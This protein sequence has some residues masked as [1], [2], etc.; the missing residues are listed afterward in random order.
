MTIMKISDIIDT[1]GNIITATEIGRF[2]G[3]D[4]LYTFCIALEKAQSQLS[5][6]TTESALATLITRIKVAYYYKILQ[7]G[8]ELDPISLKGNILV[9]GRHRLW[10][11]ILHGDT[12]VEYIR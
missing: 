3:T 4:E 11:H 9:D 7:D 8:G 2:I 6:L 12:E 1:N 10:A 5:D